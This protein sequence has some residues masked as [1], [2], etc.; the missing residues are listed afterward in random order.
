MYNYQNKI[1]IILILWIWILLW[2]PSKIFGFD[3]ADEI[4]SSFQKISNNLWKNE[5]LES[6]Y[7]SSYSKDPFWDAMNDIDNMDM[8]LK[9]AWIQ[10]IENELAANNCSLSKKKIQWILYYFVPDFRAE[11]V[12]DIKMNVWNINNKNFTFEKSTIEKYCKE[13]FV[14]MKSKW[15]WAL[16]TFRKDG[17]LR[18]DVRWISAA[19]SNDIMTNCK[20]YF[21]SAYEKWK[22]SENRIQEL[23]KSHAWSDKFRNATTDDSPY[24]I[25]LDLSN[26]GYLIYEQATPAITPVFYN[27]PVFSNSTQSLINN[28]INNFGTWMIL[29][30]RGTWTILWWHGTW[31][32]LWRSGTA[33]WWSGTTFWWSG[34][35]FWWN[36]VN[37]WWNTSN[38]QDTSF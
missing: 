36:G 28:R 23:K 4:Y 9:I 11:L 22:N 13:Y 30:W 14:C 18:E 16:E 32:I 21:W 10:Y 24:D 12:R 2:V 38:L 29:W 27:L 5:Y 31:T 25:M 3:L 6:A 1:K 19:T 17:V 7:L 8:Q 37:F 26:A 35:S 15:Y 20:E 33:F 34:A